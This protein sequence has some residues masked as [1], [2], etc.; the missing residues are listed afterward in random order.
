MESF[1]ILIFSLIKM[2]SMVILCWVGMKP[3]PRWNFKNIRC[4]QCT[5]V[6]FASF[7][8]GGFITAIVVNPPERRLA[9]HTFVGWCNS[10]VIK[11]SSRN[12]KVGCCEKASW[13]YFFENWLMPT[14]FWLNTSQ[15]AAYKPLGTIVQKILILRAI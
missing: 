15:M 6:Q 3:I 9:K 13:C 7:F 8:S 2:T 11:L 1:K 4:T 14:A 5:E 10:G 12:P